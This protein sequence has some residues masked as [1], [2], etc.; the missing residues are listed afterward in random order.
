MANSFTN[1][2]SRRVLAKLAASG[3]AAAVATTEL[4]SAAP[5]PRG[6]GLV[7][8]SQGTPEGAGGTVVFGYP[9]ATSY[10]N[11][12]IP[13]FYAGVTDIYLRRFVASDLIQSN[14]TFDDWLPDLAESWEFDGN[15]ATFHLRQGVTWHDGA[16]FTSR[17][18]LFT[19]RIIASPYTE[20]SFF[21]YVS[22][23]PNIVGVEEFRNGET[24]DISG[25]TAPDDYTVVFE[26][27][28]PYREAFL[29]YIDTIAIVPEHILGQLPEEQWVE[30]GL[31]LTDYGLGEPIGT[32]PF[33]VTNY[34][35]DQIVEYEPF[36]DYWRGE[37]LLDR[38]VFRPFTDALALTAAIENGEVH[39][40]QISAT[41]YE[42]FQQMEHIRL[43]LRPGLSSS[44]FYV[45]TRVIPQQVRQALLIGLDRETIAQTIY[46][47]TTTPPMASVIWE[48]YG[49][50]PDI[51]PYYTYDPERAAQLVAEG[52]WDPNRKLRV[53]VESIQPSNEA[54]YA[55][56][57]SYWAAIGIQAEFQVVGAEYGAVHTQE[58]WDF[59]VLLSGSGW[60]VTPSSA[61]MSFF[62]NPDS[63]TGVQNE[64]AV[65]ILNSI[66]LTDDFDTI[67][68]G[69]WQLQAMLAEQASM[70]P[71]VQ[72]PGIW[73]F[74]TKVHGDLLPIYAIWTSNYWG[75]EK[76]WADD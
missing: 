62:W 25:I 30:E 66:L 76:I 48:K 31:C 46:A 43:L 47:G 21:G 65:E 28:Q 6:T 70:L 54:L 32:G 37:P 73:A 53:L 57:F 68:A 38:L 14:E 26:M 67:Q 71:V 55:L 22:L 63:N 23:V 8:S 29:A 44:A 64:E 18:V 13:K 61:T 20:D 69:V 39:I 40:G 59:D 12:C 51:A 52:E 16:P 75:L 34:V 58:P 10:A 3:A 9:Q 7:H 11:T 50:N 1:R 74:N 36:E 35:V 72:S 19:F 4:I 60:G 5:A 2:L 27:P 15:F 45:N 41:D 17:D 42:R 49:V 33:K 56:I 24:D